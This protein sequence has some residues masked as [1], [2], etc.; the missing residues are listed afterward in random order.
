MMVITCEQSGPSYP[1]FFVGIWRA[2]APRE[3]EG[4]QYHNEMQNFEMADYSRYLG[5]LWLIVLVYKNKYL[6]TFVSKNN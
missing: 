2:S 4:L 6:T 5:W 3:Y 1:H